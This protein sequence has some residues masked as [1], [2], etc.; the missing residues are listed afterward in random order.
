MKVKLIFDFI[1]RFHNAKK[2][3]STYLNLLF[4]NSL[5]KTMYLNDTPNENSILTLAMNEVTKYY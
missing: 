4:I 3:I 2:V 5:M 1:S